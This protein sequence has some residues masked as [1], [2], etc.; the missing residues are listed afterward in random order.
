MGAATWLGDW[1]FRR[2]LLNTTDKAGKTVYGKDSRHYKLAE[3]MLT[4]EAITLAMRTNVKRG[5]LN[6]VKSRVRCKGIKIF[7]RNNG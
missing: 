5:V 7:F 4:G 3:F 6:R 2:Q 1:E